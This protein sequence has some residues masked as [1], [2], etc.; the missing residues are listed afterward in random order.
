MCMYYI[1]IGAYVLYM[2]V[3][4]IY[5]C[6]YLKLKGG[7]K[8]DWLGLLRLKE[9][10][11][12][13]FLGFSLCCIHARLRAEEATHQQVKK[14]SCNKNLLFLTN[15]PGKG[16]PT[17]T[18]NFSIINTFYFSQTTQKKKNMARTY[19]CKPRPTGK[20]R[21]SPLTRL[22]VRHPSASTWLVSERPRGVFKL[23]HCPEVTSPSPPL[24]CQCRPR[25]S[26]NKVLLPL[27][28]R[29]GGLREI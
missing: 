12:G 22:A 6:I 19:P 16:Q 5:M 8:I 29:K 21:F 27:L 11:G 20:L 28:A 18:E 15:G 26:N 23:H 25:G 17:K 4:I 1:G 7:E 2:Y 9:L 3:Y 14:K 10:H 13:E 24:E